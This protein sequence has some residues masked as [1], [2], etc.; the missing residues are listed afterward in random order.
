MFGGLTARV[1]ST[2]DPSEVGVGMAKQERTV[3]ELVR[4]IERGDLALPEMQR[5]YVWRSTRV[6]DLLDSLYRGYPS[7]VILT[8]QTASGVARNEFAVATATDGAARPMLLLDGQQRLTSLSAVI[9][10]E[11]VT[12]RGRKKPIDILFNLDHPEDVGLITEVF[13]D[14]GEGDDDPDDDLDS[15]E[16]DL[17][18]RMR[19]RT[20]VVASK[21]L[22]AL[23]NWVSVTEVMKSSSDSPFLK[24][25]GVT[26]FEHPDFEKYT[27]RLQ[28]LR[29][30]KDYSYRMDVLED[31]M[32]YEEVTE[33]FVRV[34]SLGAKLRSSDLALAQITARWPGSLAR[35][36]EFQE[37][38]DDDG[39]ELDLGTHLRMLTALLTHQSR[40]ATV[41]SF[42]R[43]TLEA[44]WGRAKKAMTHAINFAKANAGI[45]SPALL[46]SP[47]ALIALGYWADKR[48]FAPS[49]EEAD[50]MRRWLLTANA[51]G[52]WSRGSSETI[53][54]QD[55][56][57][58]RDGGGPAQL[59][60]RLL[61]QVGRLNVTPE[62]LEGRTSRSALFK[63]MF[64]AFAE[65]GASDWSTKL[66]ISVK[67]S[68][69][70]DRLQF[71]HIFPKAYMAQHGGGLKHGQI[72]DIANLAFIGGSTNN[73]ISD[74]APS[75]YLAKLAALP[76]S[77]L[78][79]QQVPTDA[80]LYAPDRFADFLA[81]RRRLISD[82]L[83]GFLAGTRTVGGSAA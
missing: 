52:R 55:L 32:S 31:S 24:K 54:D 78:P 23:P 58:L 68:G 56:A 81:A 46:S 11:L 83:N 22:A 77:P 71:H 14:G 44:G 67:H 7:G 13:E 64:L 36:R 3:D 74:T 73:R 50:A 75:D 48:A 33:I 28:R 17:Q 69:A 49:S 39:F 63:T 37:A 20:F 26:D 59:T 62:D 51:K 8:W 6:R 4:M 72:D 15:E 18:A 42:K 47:F 30:I 29:S 66:A 25:A 10:G 5:E 9:R 70:Q 2:E 38:C 57:V 79:A 19:M 34:N 61:A 35:F 16:S 43:D 82:R 1:G 41:G 40:F 76:D 65:D 45:Q 53:L 60:D 80:A 12:V 27:S 21:A